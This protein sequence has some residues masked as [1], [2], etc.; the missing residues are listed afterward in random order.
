MKDAL[1]Q[2]GFKSVTTAIKATAKSFLRNLSS[3]SYVGFNLQFY[4]LS[5]LIPCS[6]TLE[7]GQKEYIR[8]Y[9]PQLTQHGNSYT[10]VQ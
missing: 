5:F 4:C 9:V 7:T 8:T 3:N 2:Q 10:A 1:L 6:D